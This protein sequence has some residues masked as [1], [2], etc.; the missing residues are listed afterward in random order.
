MGD[1]RRHK[2]ANRKRKR[3]KSKGNHTKM[4]RAAKFAKT[5]EEHEV[6]DSDSSDDNVPLRRLVNNDL[7]PDD[8]PL[9]R[10]QKRNPGGHVPIHTGENHSIE[11]GSD[12]SNEMNIIN[13][14]LSDDNCEI[15][16]ATGNFVTT[17]AIPATVEREPLSCTDCDLPLSRTDR[18]SSAIQTSNLDDELDDEFNNDIDGISDDVFSRLMDRFESINNNLMRS[19]DETA[20]ATIRQFVENLSLEELELLMLADRVHPGV[21]NLYRTR[22]ELPIVYH[23]GILED[24]LVQSSDESSE[25]NA[26]IDQKVM[27]LLQRTTM[28][29]PDCNNSMTTQIV[30]THLARRFIVK[31]TNG[32]CPNNKPPLPKYLPKAKLYVANIVGTLL[33]MYMD[34]GI[35]GVNY[36]CWATHL[37]PFSVKMYQNH[38]KHIFDVAD[39]FRERN[40]PLIHKDIIDFYDRHDI[41][42]VN[43]DTG[44]LDITIST[45]GVYSHV[46][47]ARQ[48]TNYIACP[49]TGSMIDV[50][51]TEKCFECKRHKSEGTECRFELFH[52]SSGGLERENIVKL[53]TAS[54]DLGFRYTGYISDGD[55]KVVKTLRDL[56]PYGEG[57]P[58]EKSECGNHMINRFRKGLGKWGTLWDYEVYDK[59]EKKRVA[60]EKKRKDKEQ[61]AREKEQ[62]A[63]EREDK[64]RKEAEAKR[65]RA[66]LRA[67][68]KEEIEKERAEKANKGKRGKG[69]K[70]KS[71]GKGRD[72]DGNLPPF[73][74]APV[75]R[76]LLGKRT[77]QPTLNFSTIVEKKQ[78]V[79]VVVPSLTNMST[80]ATK[81]GGKSP[82]GYFLVPSE[83][84]TR[85]VAV[86]ES[87]TSFEM[88][89]KT[90]LESFDPSQETQ[91]S[92][93][94]LSEGALVD[95]D[96]GLLENTEGEDEQ[97]FAVSRTVPRNDGNGNE[98]DRSMD[99][100][101]DVPASSNSQQ[102]DP[103]DQDDPEDQSSRSLEEMDEPPIGG[104]LQAPGYSLSETVRKSWEKPMKSK[105][106]L[107]HLFS[108][109]CI[110]EIGSKYRLAVYS[111]H[112][113]QTQ[114]DAVLSVPMH[115]L[116]Y[117][118]SSLLQKEYYHSKCD[119]GKDSGCQFQA[120]CA[121]GEDP[122]KFWRTTAKVIGTNQTKDWT[123][124]MYAGM[125]QLYPEAWAE[126][127]YRFE[128]L[129]SDELLS[130][131]SRLRTTNVN[132]SIHQKVAH[133]VKKCKSHSTDRIKFG[134]RSLQMSQNFGYR[135]SSLLNVY[136]WLN[137]DISKGLKFKD[138]RSF[139][140]AARKHK[141]EVGT[142]HQHRK[143]VSKQVL[144]GDVARNRDGT[145]A[146]EDGATGS[147]I[148]VGTN[149]S[150]VNVG[151]T[152]SVVNVGATGSGMN[153]GARCTR[154]R[155]RSSRVYESGM[156]D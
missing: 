20:Q 111:H 85:D 135:K 97:S 80:A 50:V 128:A 115:E 120:W 63:R 154:S 49:L 47:E 18:D 81:G 108:E 68:R 145:G 112:T 25:Q 132:E 98:D 22:R 109:S 44:K 150:G 139:Q 133:F 41:G 52:G 48:C 57:V 119:K 54:E 45:D 46:K 116:D 130:R 59:R 36:I 142:T 67:R 15:E 38:C 3:S 55:A 134:T 113:L 84:S 32:Y 136:G 105:K 1:D 53:F 16:L 9:S 127:L 90:T 12:F 76:P 103:D 126:L 60:D 123:H 71:S 153:V 83:G 62:K 31:C 92:S 155:N 11:T 5:Q 99:V 37:K 39:K 87:C 88:S 69:T 70:V 143:K 152:G 42:H 144:G 4:M 124:G 74:D 102:D 156:G 138:D 107:A 13:A 101:L 137:D 40:M 78:R 43:V 114:K 104:R 129:S 73:L 100:Q 19:D 51:T 30:G 56:K 77:R 66:E 8:M 106:P 65:E 79:S 61:K 33:A 2:H 89:Q 125:D 35:Q 110:R 7:L 122:A 93:Q 121:N 86:E 147:G 91:E 26:L 23:Q 29:C 34:M 17:A 75:D 131:C 14:N 96:T 140:S 6:C 149:G 27:D 21:R 24:D 151:A 72:S 141:L 117:Q 94:P 28:K 146:R 10:I 82:V 118:G 64:A 148:D 58:L 95:Q